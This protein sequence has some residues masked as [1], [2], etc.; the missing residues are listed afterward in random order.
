MIEI[1]ASALAQLNWRETRRDNPDEEPPAAVI[2]RLVNLHRGQIEANYG[3]RLS[4]GAAAQ[5]A[6]S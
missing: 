5:V 4:A 1:F 3:P 6:A 2:D